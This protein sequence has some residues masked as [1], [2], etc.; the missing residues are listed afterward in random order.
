[1]RFLPDGTEIIYSAWRS[2]DTGRWY[3]GEP[4]NL[5][6]LDR[7][8]VHYQTK[9]GKSGYFTIAAPLPSG[10]GTKDRLDKLAQLLKGNV[11]YYLA[12]RK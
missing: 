6:S 11:K 4:V 3:E 12:K 7:L 8:R 9:S 2:A 10:I 5:Q 1:M